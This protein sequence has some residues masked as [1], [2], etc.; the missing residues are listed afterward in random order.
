MVAPAIVAA[1][2]MAAA[3]IGGTIYSNASSAAEARRNRRFQERM[4]NTAH[5]REMSDL[6]KA[7]LNPILSGKYGGASTPPGSAAQVHQMDI[8]GAATQGAQAYADLQLKRAT[9][10]QA[11]SAATLNTEQAKDV[12]QTRNSRLGVMLSQAYQQLQS[13][14]LSA[15]QRPKVIQEIKN[16]EAQMQ[17]I[18]AENVKKKFLGE[19]YKMPSSGLEAA[20]KYGPKWQENFRG[21]F[22]PSSG[23]YD[24]RFDSDPAKKRR[25]RGTSGRW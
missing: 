17:G 3:S 8:A 15:E 21:G 4:S 22:G 14:N 5:Q 25:G 16:L 1:G 10:A 13:G 18:R 2:L 23:G 12:E 11:N 6:A 7:G 20:K 9:A 19:I 24:P